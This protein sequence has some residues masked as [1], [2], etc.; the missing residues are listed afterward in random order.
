MELRE[1]LDQGHASASQ[2]GEACGVRVQTIGR[3]ANGRRDASPQL[4]IRVERA[5]GG[6]VTRQELRPD[7][8]GEPVA[9]EREEA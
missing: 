7:I 2:I 1:Y 6:A 5:T 3:V 8:F 9:A 4:A